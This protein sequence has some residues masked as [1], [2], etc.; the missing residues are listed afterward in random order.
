MPNPSELERVEQEKAEKRKT[1]LPAPTKFDVTIDFGRHQVK[2]TVDT[3]VI[4]GSDDEAI[5]HYVAEHIAPHLSE[6]FKA[7]E[8]THGR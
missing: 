8:R 3:E 4:A 2:F 7:E 5:A 6:M 1:E